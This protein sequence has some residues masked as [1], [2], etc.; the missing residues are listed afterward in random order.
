MYELI[1]HAWKALVGTKK[2][3]FQQLFEGLKIEQMFWYLD[4]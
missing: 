1:K 3:K 4:H 2:W